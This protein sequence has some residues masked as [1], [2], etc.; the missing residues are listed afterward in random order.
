MGHGGRQLK[1]G[2]DLGYYCAINISK[3]LGPKDFLFI[4]LPDQN[5]FSV[6]TARKCAD[7]AVR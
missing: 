3:R 6:S 2:W 5:A 7:L 1:Q 4:F